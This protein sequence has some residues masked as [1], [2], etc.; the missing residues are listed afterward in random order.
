MN[1]S[2]TYSPRLPSDRSLSRTVTSTR[3][4]ASIP[5]VLTPSREDL[6]RRHVEGMCAVQVEE[7]RV[8]VRY[9]VEMLGL[10]PWALRALCALCWLQ[11]SGSPS[12]GLDGMTRFYPTRHCEPCQA[13]A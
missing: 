8:N 1:H 2:T 12:M 13:R 5:I 3:T 11:I 9:E 10:T 4:L 7:D 6:P